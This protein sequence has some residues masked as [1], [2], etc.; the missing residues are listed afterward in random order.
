MCIPTRLS[1]SNPCAICL[2][3]MCF[4]VSFGRASPRNHA[5]ALCVLSFD[6]TSTVPETSS[7]LQEDPRPGDQRPHLAMNNGNCSIHYYTFLFAVAAERQLSMADVKDG[8]TNRGEKRTVD[9]DHVYCCT[10]FW[11]YLSRCQHN[12]TYTITENSAG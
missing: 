5:C 8:P 1:M 2:H 12:I 6:G 10:S 4:D 3:I 9:F 7:G 11:P